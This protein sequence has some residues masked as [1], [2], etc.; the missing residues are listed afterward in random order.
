MRPSYLAS[1]VDQAVD[2]FDE[3]PGVRHLCV[4]VKRVSV[5]PDGVNEEKPPI[6]SRSK[7]MNTHA[8]G[9]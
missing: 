1:F 5:V 9:L 2:G 3:G 8:A 6:A 4:N 7:C